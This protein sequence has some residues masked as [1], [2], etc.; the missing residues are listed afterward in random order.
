VKTGLPVG[1][2]VRSVLPALLSVLLIGVTCCRCA[3]PPMREYVLDAAPASRTASVIQTALPIV[4]IERVRLPDYLDST[5]ILTRRDG[6]VVPSRTGRWADRFSVGVTRALTAFLANRLTSLVVTS[7]Q[8]IESPVLRVL[9]D[10]IAFESTTDGQVLLAARWTIT[11]GT[12][13]K[14]LAA[15]QAT[16]TEPIA[17]AR[18]DSSTVAAMSLAVENLGNRIAAAIEHNLP[19][20]IRTR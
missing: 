10:V 13:Q 11:D 15:E 14:S 5:D 8:P 17:A 16:L 19:T 9:V 7:G 1:S 20:R 3:A 4:K 6:Q 2:R 12:G 18:D